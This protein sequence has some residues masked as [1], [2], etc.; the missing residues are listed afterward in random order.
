MAINRQYIYD[1]LKDKGY[2]KYTDDVFRQA[3]LKDAFNQGDIKDE[4]LPVV[5]DLLKT[6]PLD[7]NPGGFTNR[8]TELTKEFVPSGSSVDTLRSSIYNSDPIISHLK[9]NTALPSKMTAEDI[10]STPEIPEEPDGFIWGNLKRGVANNFGFAELLSSLIAK[11]VG[12]DSL[13]E[14]LKSSAQANFDQAE[15]Y[16]KSE[17]FNDSPLA[18]V[19][20]VILEGVPDIALSLATGGVAELACWGDQDGLGVMPH[21]N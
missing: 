19:G 11:G 21:G 16:A 4:A 20:Q 10:F 15:H 18:W 12:A 17:S 9:K 6:N 7:E 5:Q 8:F 3:Q 13:G 14:A 2:E 1:A